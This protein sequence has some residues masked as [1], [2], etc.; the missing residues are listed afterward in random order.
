M[1]TFSTINA[2]G[3]YLDILR[4]FVDVTKPY[5]PK[6]SKHE[7]QHFIETESSPVAE[8]AQRLSP[9]KLRQAKAEFERMLEQGI[10]RPFSN[11]WAISLHLVLKKSG[12]YRPCGDYRR[13]N[14]ITVPDR[15]PISNLH[16]FAHRLRECTVFSTLDLTRAYHQVPVAPRDRPKITVI[17]LFGLFEF[18]VMTLQH[19]TNFS[20]ADGHSSPWPR[21]SFRVYR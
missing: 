2:N 15:Y 20:K 21:F 19:G 12:D 6:E 17:T 9:E 10:Y 16:D 1:P 11:Q 14:R 5:T 4:E 8:S 13:L 3:E 7:V 18:N